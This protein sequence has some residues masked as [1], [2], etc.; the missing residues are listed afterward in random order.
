MRI[1][2]GADEPVRFE[3]DCGA[4]VDAVEVTAFGDAEPSFMPGRHHGLCNRPRCPF[5]H[6]LLDSKQRC[7]HLDCWACWVFIPLPEFI[8]GDTT[9]RST[10]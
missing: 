5:C 7:E 6:F 10:S 9:Y 8:L 3:C 1:L 2:G 4:E